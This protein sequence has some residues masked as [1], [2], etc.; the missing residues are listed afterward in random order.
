[1]LCADCRVTK[2]FM[3][4]F[5]K[6]YRTRGFFSQGGDL[7]REELLFLKNCIGKWG[8]F[9]IA[10][11][12]NSGYLGYLD[13]TISMYMEGLYL[14][15]KRYETLSPILGGQ[16]LLP[17]KIGEAIVKTVPCSM[18]LLADIT[19]SVVGTELPDDLDIV[20]EITEGIPTELLERIGLTRVNST[21]TG[22]DLSER[23]THK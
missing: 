21:P 18:E 16:G 7:T 17:L 19:V 22:I 9:L 6:E 3:Q 12:G 1:M 15:E 10:M 5:E 20:K 2:K 14:L 23:H 8:N 11:T 13:P 4:I